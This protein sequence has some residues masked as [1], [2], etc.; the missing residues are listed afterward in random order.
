MSNTTEL[1]Y[2]ER[3]NVLRHLVAIGYATAEGCT[4]EG[5]KNFLGDCCSYDPERNAVT[6]ALKR[7][8]GI[9]PVTIECIYPA[10]ACIEFL[11]QHG[12]D[13]NPAQLRA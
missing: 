5:F 1:G 8:W 2:R 9:G 12:F 11:T 7:T 13:S 3:A 6:I 4:P 10:W